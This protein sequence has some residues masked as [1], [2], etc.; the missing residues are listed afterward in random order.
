MSKQELH[1]DAMSMLSSFCFVNVVGSVFF[2]SLGF[3]HNNDINKITSTV[4]ISDG[5]SQASLSEASLTVP[6]IMHFPDVP[7]HAYAQ[8]LTLCGQQ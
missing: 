2:V 5:V 7:L 6:F 3:E 4:K 8:P 1:G